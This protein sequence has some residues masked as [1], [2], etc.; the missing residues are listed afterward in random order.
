[1][2]KTA[3]VLSVKLVGRMRSTPADYIKARS[4]SSGCNKARYRAI[5]YR[6]CQRG[7]CLANGIR[8]YKYIMSIKLPGHAFSLFPL[9][10]MLLGNA[11]AHSLFM[12][13]FPI[14]GRTM[15]ISELLT[16][17]LLSVSA[18]GM[19]I[20]APFW[21][22]YT[23]KHGQKAPIVI[24]IMSTALFLI[25]TAGL[26]E[27]QTSLELT[28]PTLFAL[29]FLLRLT[30]SV[31]VA[32]LMPSAQAYVADR[33]SH[34]Q[35]L[36]GMGFI[37]A[38]FGF[39]SIIGGYFA[40]SFGVKHFPSVLFILGIIMLIIG[41]GYRF[42]KTNPPSHESQNTELPFSSFPQPLTPIL[43]FALITFCVLLVYGI[44]QQ[45]T[46][47]RLQDQLGFSP[48]EALKGSGGL[49]TS[50]MISMATG[51][52][53]LTY[54]TTEHSNRLMVIGFFVGLLSLAYLAISNTYVDMLIAMICLGGAMSLIIPAN[55]ALLSQ[56]A[57]KKHQAYAASINLLGKGLGWTAGPVMGSLLYQFT[58]T[59]PVWSSIGLFLVALGITIY[60]RKKTGFK[61]T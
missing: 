38:T 53:I 57:G 16:G 26:I 22:R 49:L 23:D 48:Q 60:Q 1:M 34:R 27:F 43:P 39:G 8:S 42:L 36:S 5:T 18:F 33:T 44:L 61:K 24:G 58:P 12:I 20:F 4:Q 9:M 54:F 52:V 7:F 11:I 17:T 21:G 37:G 56:T 13:G 59:S 14:I 10:V 19:M 6:Q 15:G 50:S 46:G 35:R 2:T 29:F 45:T 40:M 55:L 41:F 32:G 31:G 28:I 30:Q 25:L 51:Q 47:L 3:T